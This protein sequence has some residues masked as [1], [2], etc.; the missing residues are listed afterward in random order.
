MIQ[1]QKCEPRQ[2]KLSAPSRLRSGNA[3][4]HRNDN[5]NTNC[6]MSLAE[7]NNFVDHNIQ[8]LLFNCLFPRR[9]CSK[10]VSRET[11]KLSEK[12]CFATR[13]LISRFVIQEGSS[14]DC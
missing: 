14:V 2:L 5:A 12:Y 13:M 11:S 7:F 10:L 8:L 3:L 9:H 1:T 6:L 4:H